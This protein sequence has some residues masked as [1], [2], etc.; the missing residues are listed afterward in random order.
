MSP[1]GG[2]SKASTGT[3]LDQ[4]KSRLDLMPMRA[5]L[6]VGAVLTFGAKKYGANNWRKVIGWRW[7]YLGAGLRHVVTFMLGERS[8]P[9]T[10]LHH[11]SHAL[12]CFLFVLE[13][14]L[15]LEHEIHGGMNITVPDGDAIPDE[16][17]KEPPRC[18]ADGCSYQAEANLEFCRGHEMAGVNK[19]HKFTP[20][21]EGVY[22]SPCSLCGSQAVHVLHQTTPDPSTCNHFIKDMSSEQR[23][24]FIDGG[25]VEV[26][27]FLCG[28][29]LDVTMGRA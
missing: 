20:T 25:S 27:C 7:R 22:G 19:P 18:K 15:T 24:L 16:Q 21:T 1:I 28:A 5:L 17:P 9:E 3:K 29:K 12:C 8:D 13:N 11:L 4:G 2:V 23:K 26:K 6:E 14:E 10:G